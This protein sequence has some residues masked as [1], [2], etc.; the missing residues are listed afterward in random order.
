VLAEL[1]PDD[2]RLAGLPFAAVADRT[3]AQHAMIEA[4]RRAAA[5]EAFG[6]AT[7]GHR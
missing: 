6:V 5:R 3:A 2:P 7:A 4:E 1:G